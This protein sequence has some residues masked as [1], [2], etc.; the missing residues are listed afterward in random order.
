MPTIYTDYAKTKYKGSYYYI[1]GWLTY[2]FTETAKE[3]SITF[4][5]GFQSKVRAF[6]MGEIKMK[7]SDGTHTKTGT[8]SW[9]GGG[10]ATKSI[11]FVPTTTWTF[12]KKVDTSQ[13]IGV[14]IHGSFG[15]TRF[16]QMA[17]FETLVFNVAALDEPDTALTATRNGTDVTLSLKVSTN[18]ALSVVN[19]GITAN[20]TPIQP[21]WYRN[22]TRVTFPRTV[23]GTE[24]YTATVSADIMHAVNYLALGN[25]GIYAYRETAKINYVYAPLWN[26]TLTV[27]QP[28][29]ELYPATGKAKIKVYAY[30]YVSRQFVQL[31]K[32]SGWDINI[33]GTNQWSVDVDLTDRYVADST[34]PTASAQLRVDY[35][36]YDEQ[37]IE[38]KIAIFNTNRNAN[39]STGLASNVFIGGCSITD[40]SSRV[41]YSYVNNPLYMPDTNYIEVGS[42]DTKVMGLVKVDDY[43]GVVKQ[44]KSTDTA[45][46][47]L[48]ATSFDNE[49]TFA[50]KPCVNGVGAIGQFC[51]NVLGDETL[52]LS[53]DGVVAIEQAEDEQ[54]R[55]KDRSYFVNG[56]LTKEFG[57][58]NAY[59]F[60]WKGFYILAINNHAYVLDGSQ[61]N[62]W[63]NTRTNLVYE[64]YYID[65]FPAKC[66]VSYGGDLWFSDFDGNMCRLKNE[67]DEDPYSDNGE[68]IECEWATILDDDGSVHYYKNLQKK[69]T[70]VAIMPFENTSAAISIKK[71]EE[72]E[73]FIG[74]LEAENPPVPRVFYVNK[75]IKKYK[76]LQFIVRNAEA[77]EGFGLDE[78]IKSYTFGSYAK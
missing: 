2:S 69:G 1:R 25:I 3:K 14:T 71:D 27:N 67:N 43:L 47:L 55:I 64:C 8:K 7:V 32:D 33:L 35:E 60:V 4:T 38:D 72:D 48:Y 58:E 63:G 34:V 15:N 10:S 40:Y 78:I 44:S 54:S 73:M 70:V 57:L 20:G 9:T 5:A 66:M 22:G 74:T 50:V 39:F 68:A 28:V 36:T 56:R 23:N 75:K 17:V 11:T 6:S 41:W 42:N 12:K 46:Y 77:G 13:K 21:A 29:P 51:F 16:A 53:P 37:G 31:P 61:R 26:V 49:T 45:V 24:T 18:R 52:F 30:D 19:P 65:N 62:S 59:S 76:R